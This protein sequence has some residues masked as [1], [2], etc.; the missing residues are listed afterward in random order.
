LS[1]TQKMDSLLNQKKSDS[2]LFKQFEINLLNKFQ[3]KRDSV[4]NI[5]VKNYNTSIQNAET[6][7]I[8]EN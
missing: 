7:N 6:V 4:N 1:N 3:I 8:G 5:P 2:I